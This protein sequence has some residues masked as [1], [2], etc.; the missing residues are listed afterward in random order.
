MNGKDGCRPPNSSRAPLLRT[1]SLGHSGCVKSK[2]GSLPSPKV[3][4]MSCSNFSGLKEA[5][6]C[7]IRR[8][9]YRNWL[10]AASGMKRMK[11]SRWKKINCSATA[12]NLADDYYT[13][14]LPT[15]RTQCIKAEMIKKMPFLLRKIF[16]SRELKKIAPCGFRL[17]KVRR[18][19]FHLEF[20]WQPPVP[21]C[22]GKGPERS[23]RD[24]LG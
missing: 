6:V 19:G 7:K 8:I 13:R 9:S 23:N 16:I 14:R 4:L 22:L 18:K 12:R 3:N 5:I 17:C 20:L 21:H 10:L 15:H 2:L 24:V 1:G 11:K